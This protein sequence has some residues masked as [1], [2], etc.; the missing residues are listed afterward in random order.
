VF[1][2][3]FTTKEHGK[4]TGLGLSTVM[5]IVEQ[6]GG[7][8]TVDSELGRGTTFR[9][10]LPVTDRDPSEPIAIART[11]TPIHGTQRILVVEDEVDVRVL[12]REV[13]SQAG[14]EV[15]DAADGLHALTVAASVSGE[16]DL[17]LTDVIMPKLSGRELA[18]RF[19]KLRPETRVLYMSGYTD[20]KLGHHGLLDPDIELI[21]KPL[22]PDELLRRVRRLLA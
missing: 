15:I 5:G 9:V 20:D 11:A 16:I 3:F 10:T 12:I 2:P 7:H 1:D 6:S 21:Q 18:K 4:G 17:L 13:L 19:V 14:Y 8:I 22:T